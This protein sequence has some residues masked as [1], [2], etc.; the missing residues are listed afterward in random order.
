M[1][2]SSTTILEVTTIHLINKEHGLHG[3]PQSASPTDRE[4]ATSRFAAAQ[5]LFGQQQSPILSPIIVTRQRNNTEPSLYSKLDQ[6]VAL[7]SPSADHQ[8][9]VSSPENLSFTDS[10]MKTSVRQLP[11]PR[12]APSLASTERPPTP[13]DPGC[14]LP[15][16]NRSLLPLDMTRSIKPKAAS[17][18]SVWYCRYDK[19]VIFD[20]IHAGNGDS[21]RKLI[22]RSSR[23]L[24]ISRKNCPKEKITIG[25][26]C[27]HCQGLLKRRTWVFEERMLQCRVCKGCQARCWKE[28]E[29]GQE[30]ARS[31]VNPPAPVDQLLTISRPPTKKIEPTVIHYQPLPIVEDPTKRAG[32]TTTCEEHPVKP[33]ELVPACAGSISTMHVEP[34]NALEN[35]LDTHTELTSMHEGLDT[36]QA[37]TPMVI[38]ARVPS[39]PSA[40]EVV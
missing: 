10:F 35:R 29:T 30:T 7:T 3:D 40:E 18:G 28:W 21:S 15:G 25:L 1:S 32:L 27:T 14:L 5:K 19:L 23:G 31:E 33:T 34:A 36:S 12:L 9:A 13:V 2:T 22:T 26:P 4:R 6:S 39:E 16:P 24:D 8:R 38:P 17:G 20:G 37:P 11:K